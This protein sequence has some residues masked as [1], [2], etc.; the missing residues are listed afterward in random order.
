MPGAV[1]LNNLPPFLKRI[2]EKLKTIREHLGL[3]TPDD[4]TAGVGARTGAEI[5]AYVLSELFKT[6]GMPDRSD[7]LEV[8]FRDL[9][10]V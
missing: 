5:L 3:T 10:A 6:C 4:L 9:H 8:T 2:R 7:N 1:D